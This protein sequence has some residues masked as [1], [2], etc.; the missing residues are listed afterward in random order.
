MSKFKVRSD[1]SAFA[2]D[3]ES[4]LRLNDHK[5]GWEDTSVVELI[6]MLRDEVEELEDAFF[7]YRLRVSE[8]CSVVSECSDV[9]NFAMMIASKMKTAKYKTSSA[10]KGADNT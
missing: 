10:Y 1:V 5:G 7:N 6:S 2:K 3:M 4:K 8:S 9:A